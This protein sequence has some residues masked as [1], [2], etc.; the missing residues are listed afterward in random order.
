MCIR[1]R[2]I[3]IIAIPKFRT[4]NAITFASVIAVVA[5]WIKRYLIIIPTLEATL[6]PIHDL[7]PEYVHYS[8]TWVEWAITFAGVAMFIL[9]FFLISKFIPII[10]TM[11][12]EEGKDYSRLRK[13]VKEKN[14][15]EKLIEFKRKGKST[16]VGLILL[17]IPLPFLNASETQQNNQLNS[18]LN[19]E[20][21]NKT[22]VKSLVATLTS[23]EGRTT[24][25]LS[26][27]LI[28]I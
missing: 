6:M 12:V 21:F 4:I 23:R 2:P 1:D 25:N 22:G 5:L 7:R 26:L 3:A 20:Y 16:I 18:R 17:A 10:P 28:H 19:I 8:P 13:L 27:S 9:L 24:T 15:K 14:L 11:T